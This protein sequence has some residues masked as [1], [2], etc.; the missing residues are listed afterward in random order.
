MRRSLA[1]AQI[2]AAYEE[3]GEPGCTYTPPVGA[4]ILD[5]LLMLS[6]PDVSIGEGGGAVIAQTTIAVR[7]KDATPEKGGSFAVPIR[8]AADAVIGS[9]TFLITG[10][11]EQLDML[12]LEWTAIVRKV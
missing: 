2:D 8:D 10:E 5:L 3:L 7:T 9:E 6:Q 12:R 1:A 11:P 4:P